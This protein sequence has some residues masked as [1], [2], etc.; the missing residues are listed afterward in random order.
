MIKLYSY[1]RSSAAYRV[2]IGLNL[3]DIAHEI[4]PVNM[5]L[6]GG[7]QLTSEYRQINPQGLVPALIDDG[8][9]LT[10]S[11]AILEYL[12]EKYPQSG[13]LPANIADKARARQLAQIIACD[14]HP[15]NNLRVLK[16]IKREFAQD[17]DAKDTWYKHWMIQGFDALESELTK[18]RGD[19][20]YCLG[21]KVTLVDLFLIPQM[22]NAHRFDTPLDNYPTL[23]AIEQACLELEAFDKAK[24]ENQIDAVT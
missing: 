7:Q 13:L 24:P 23:V 1:W 5:L 17:D 9:T 20:P 21:K 4:I 2:R 15:L 19:G 14:I 12:D 18:V 10:Q 16:Y 22:Y 6:D 11:L 8:M 3:K